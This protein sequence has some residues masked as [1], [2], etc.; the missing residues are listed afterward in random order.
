MRSSRWIARTVARSNGVLAELPELGPVELVGLPELVDE[1]DDLVRV[2]DRVG[3]ELRRDDEVDRAALRL[4][5]VEQ[6]PD[7]RL[8][9]RRA[10][11]GTT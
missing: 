7:E 11:R 10:P 3:G 6:P 4:L 8:A 2:A 1:P 5:E 9:Q